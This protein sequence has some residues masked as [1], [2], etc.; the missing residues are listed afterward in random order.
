[1]NILNVTLMATAAAVFL[2]IWLAS[3]IG[4]LRREQKV[5]IGHGHSAELER[6]MRAQANFIENTP[7]FL[8]LVGALELSRA[9]QFALAIVATAFLLS[10]VAHAL[11]MEGGTLHRW[12][13]IGILGSFLATA[14]LAVWAIACVISAIMGWF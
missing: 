6:R 4:R 13:T 14:V 3:R 10:R 12:R 11:G 7:L 5:S 8:I 2:N 9:S 1:M